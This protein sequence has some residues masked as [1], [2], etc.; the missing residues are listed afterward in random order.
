MCDNENSLI[1]NSFCVPFKEAI[2]FM[3][4]HNICDNVKM[5]FSP[6][7]IYHELSGKNFPHI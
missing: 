7:G 3:L 4:G 1:S 2:M 5:Y 6:K